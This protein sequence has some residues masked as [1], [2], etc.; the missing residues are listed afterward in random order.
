MVWYTRAGAVDAVFE[1]A[2]TSLDR[3]TREG[4]VGGAWRVSWVP[5]MLP[6]RDDGRLQRFDR[7]VR[8]FE[9]WSEYA[10]GRLLRG[11]RAPGQ[12]GVKP[13]H[14]PRVPLSFW[15]ADQGVLRR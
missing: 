2:F 8:L 14:R 4:T 12:G 3:Y 11:G 1:I 15:M 9:Y 6:F 5:A 10:S 7:R 13:A